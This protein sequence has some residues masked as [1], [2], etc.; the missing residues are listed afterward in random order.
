MRAGSLRYGTVSPGVWILKKLTD[1]H[2][3]HGI[4]QASVI[5]SAKNNLSPDLRMIMT[6]YKLPKESSFA[7]FDSFSGSRHEDRSAST[8]AGMKRHFPNILW[9]PI[10]SKRNLNIERVDILLQRRIRIFLPWH[11][12]K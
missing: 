3:S 12:A 6:V 2:S 10:S 7:L 8:P 1:P 9:Q 11:R 4:T 5:E